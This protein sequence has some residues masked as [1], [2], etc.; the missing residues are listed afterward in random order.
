MS[1]LH[2]SRGRLVNLFHTHILLTTT[3]LRSIDGDKET[4]DAS[5]LCVLDVLLG[6]LAV[7][8]DVELDEEVL[9]W[10]SIVDDVVE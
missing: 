4:L 6:D 7:T 8:V 1:L 3:E 9:A 5:L 2:L 10:C